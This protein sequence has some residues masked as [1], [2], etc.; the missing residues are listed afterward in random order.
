MTMYLHRKA[1]AS[2]S[3]TFGRYGIRKL[4]GMF[5]MIIL[6]EQA[7]DSNFPPVTGLANQQKVQ[8]LLF[9]IL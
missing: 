1:S 4:G 8:N 2:N 9:P 6:V 7:E 3:D 5:P